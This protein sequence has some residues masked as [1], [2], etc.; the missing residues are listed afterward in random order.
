MSVSEN[1]VI[2]LGHTYGLL[3]PLLHALTWK[4]TYQVMVVSTSDDKSLRWSSHGDFL[5]LPE[6]TPQSSPDVLRDALPEWSGAMLFPVDIDTIHWTRTHAE[7]LARDWTI[8]PLPEL[9]AFEVASDKAAISPLAEAAGFSIPP[10]LRLPVDASTWPE[11]P[12]GVTFPVLLKPTQGQSGEGIELLPDASAWKQR[13]TEGNS[14][15]PCLLQNFIDGED[16]GC[17]ALCQ[18]GETLA[19]A[20][21]RSLAR[22]GSFGAIRSLQVVEHAEL[23]SCLRTL[24]K[25]LNWTGLVN[26]DVRQGTDGRLYFLDM[27]PRTFGNVR[28][29]LAVGI[30]FGDLACQLALGKTITPAAPRMARYLCPLDALLSWVGCGPV[31]RAGHK[32]SFREKTHSLRYVFSD[33]FLYVAGV[34]DHHRVVKRWKGISSALVSLQAKF[35]SRWKRLCRKWGAT[36]PQ[37]RPAL[38]MPVPQ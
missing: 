7:E 10:Q 9:P 32:I 36:S 18:D 16:L 3:L 26:I 23:E 21:F 17:S 34:F 6:W 37:A 38:R 20:S 15:G 19:I 22:R 11:L 2:L 27:N 24:L 33:P 25:S 12:S 1:R 4:K 5:S 14:A 8:V 28:S 31:A 29:L 35:S 30:N 13:R